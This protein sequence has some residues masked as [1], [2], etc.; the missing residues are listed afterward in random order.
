MKH[1]I[2][3]VEDEAAISM[4]LRDRLE[5]E[6]YEV[7]VAGDGLEGFAKASTGKWDLLILDLMLPGRGGLEVCRDLRGQGITTP[8]LMLTA[9]DQTV[10][11]VLGLKIGADD[12]LTKPFEMIEL[13]ARVEALLRRRPGHGPNATFYPIGDYVLDIRK[14][15][16]R[17]G[18]ETTELSTQEFKLLKYLCEHKGEVLDRDELLDAVWG[19]DEVPYTRTVDVH[20][21]WLRQKLGDSKSQKLIV[22]IRGRGYKF[23]G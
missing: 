5:S 18:G 14:Q 16:L 19:Y 23:E 15:A 9:R 3:I 4:P 21:A 1:K 17:R 12:Y 6:G 10:D 22:T 7:G 8:V 2:L 11:K 13:L 20:I